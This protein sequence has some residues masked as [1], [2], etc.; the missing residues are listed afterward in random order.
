MSNTQNQGF[1]R[2]PANSAET[3]QEQVR[4][5]APREA[6]ARYVNAGRSDAFRSVD[7]GSADRFFETYSKVIEGKARED[8]TL[9][10]LTGDITRE[11]S[12]DYGWLVYATKIGQDLYYH[13]LVIETNAEPVAK[14]PTRG[15]R[16]YRSETY[17][18]IATIDGI[19]RDV[20]ERIEAW[21]KQNIKIT[22][23]YI[24]TS[25]TIIP[26]EADLTDQR[27]VK[28]FALSADD[29]NLAV[30]MTDAPFDA[31]YVR[32]G[33]VVRG[34]IGFVNAPEAVDATGMPLRQD[35]KGVINEVIERTSA[36]ILMANDR[37]N[38]YAS[39]SGFVN[40]RFYGMKQPER[41]EQPSVAC[42]VPEVVVSE[43]NLYHSVE[44]GNFERMFLGLAMLPYMRT[45]D[46]WMNQYITNIQQDDLKDVG[47]FGYGLDIQNPNYIEIT[48]EEY[49]DTRL[50]RTALENLFLVDD[51]VD[52]AYLIR[53]GGVGYA[54]QKILIDIARGSREAEAAVIYALDNLTNGA[55]SD[56]WSR[57]KGTTIVADAIRMPTGYYV[58]GSGKRPIEDIDTLAVLNSLKNNYPELIEDWF[59]CTNP[60][61]CRYDYNERM[62]KLVE[63]LQL[64]TR[65]SFTMK[66]FATKV[67]FDPLFLEV[68]FKAVQ[69]SGLGMQVEFEGDAGF[70]R[71]SRAGG[72]RYALRSD[73]ARTERHGYDARTRRDDR[74]AATGYR[75]RR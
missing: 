74:Y 67:Y 73:L 17:D 68:L 13:L 32:E 55:F 7:G 49:A 37:G 45:G 3:V 61:E 53:E 20:V 33:A 38:T 2:G 43:V 65:N 4:E 66:G 30:S 18:F 54:T 59:E 40:A 64:V 26:A 24:S 28:A 46:R 57:A 22:G 70:V 58:S 5:Q 9:L 56:L 50:F 69:Q 75:S 72:Q 63:I 12:Q 16:R 10:K 29:A 27:T 19:N 36:N 39:I 6:T 11:L 34:T 44:F 35:F 71:N 15:D 42:Y 1:T 52:F 51:G 14:R 23:Q 31:R 48:K 21:V 41:G 8:R 25:A 47:G 62:T 60:G